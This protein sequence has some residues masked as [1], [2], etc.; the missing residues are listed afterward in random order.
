MPELPETEVVS[1]Q[2]RHTCLGACIERIEIFH[3]EIL[4][5]K[6][7]LKPEWYEKSTLRDVQRHGKNMIVVLQNG[8]ETG[9]LGIRLGM[10]GQLLKREEGAVPVPHTHAVIR[11][12]DRPFELHFRDPRRFG[13]ISMLSHPAPLQKGSD[14]LTLQMTAFK[15]KLVRSKGRIKAVLMNQEILAGIGNIYANEILFEA[16]LHPNEK[17]NRIKPD[18]LKELFLSVRRVLRR[19]IQNGGTTI[20]D[21]RSLDGIPGRFQY[22]LKVYGKDGESCPRPGCSGIIR[23]IRPSPQVQPSFYCPRCQRKR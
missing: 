6:S 4:D 15:E 7:D 18:R 21:F 12:V 14:P 11:F 13:R 1:R 17:V 19:G 20:R 23:A 16:G 8:Q 3:P 22:L 5:R 10:S 9:F 2:L